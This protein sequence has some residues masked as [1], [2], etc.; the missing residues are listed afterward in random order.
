MKNWKIR[1]RLFEVVVQIAGG[2]GRL[3]S[4]AAQLAAASGQT[5][6]TQKEVGLAARD[7]RDLAMQLNA[8]VARFAL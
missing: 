1:Y 7:L 5:S 6:S 8:T 2:A 4:N 3:G